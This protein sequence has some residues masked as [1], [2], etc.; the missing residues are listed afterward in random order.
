MEISKEESISISRA[1]SILSLNRSMFYYKSS[2]DDGEVIALLSEW[3][4]KKPTRGFWY[5]YGRIRA[6]GHAINHKRLK[7]VYTLM[8]LNKR[9][10]HKK[11]LPARVKVPLEAPAKVN[12]SWTMDFMHDSLTSG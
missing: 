11:R 9:R 3:A 10:K 2:R 4:E 8:K 5:Y 7:R 12:E 6:E 1:C